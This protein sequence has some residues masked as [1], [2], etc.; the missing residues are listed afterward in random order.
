LPHPRWISGRAKPC[1]Q[2]ATTFIGRSFPAS[3]VFADE[4][5]D[6]ARL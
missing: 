1:L 3:A 5:L 6:F 4:A 2:V